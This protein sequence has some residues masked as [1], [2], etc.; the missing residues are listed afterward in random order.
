M[1]ETASGPQKLNKNDVFLQLRKSISEGDFQSG[2]RLP[3]ERDLAARFGV[4]RGTLRE[5][6]RELEKTGM[7]ERRQGSGTY[8]TYDNETPPPSIIESVRP[9]ELVDTRLA[10]EPHIC[11]KAVLHATDADFRRA[12]QLLQSMEKCVNDPL[13]FS[14]YDE[15][16]HQMLA[17]WSGNRLMQWM[18]QSMSGARAHSQWAQVRTITLTP[19][20][21]AIYNSQHRAI[22]DAIKAREPEAAATHMKQHVMTARESLQ[23]IAEV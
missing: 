7:V 17:A 2:E 22:V 4:A 12:E 21:I 5:G 9:L 8:V 13:E 23:N 1:N 11:R 15:E 14:R 20:I 16:F 3:A 19:E 10:L 6:L 18:A